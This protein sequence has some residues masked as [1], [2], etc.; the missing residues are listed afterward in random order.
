[1]SKFVEHANL[2]HDVKQLIVGEKYSSILD[3]SLKKLDVEPI[4]CPPNPFIDKR[5]SGH[6]DLSVLH[7][8]GNTVFLSSNLQNNDFANKLEEI[9]T[10][11]VFPQ[12]EMGKKYPND[13][14]YNICVMGND[15]FCSPKVSQNSIVDYLTNNR[16]NRIA[17]KQG[18]CRCSICVVDYRSIITADRGIYLK[19]IE[20]GIDCLLIAPGYIALDGYDYGFIGGCSFKISDRI[21]CFTGT[22]DEHPDKQNI[23]NYLSSKNVEPILLTDL[24]VFDIGSAVPLTEK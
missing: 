15:Y 23:L 14:Q 24:P 17:V 5:L 8:G 9:G 18:Y 21:I 1:M 7:T 3:D 6:A 22:L 16:H 20:N 4:Y 13:S 2:P 11:T 10:K 12:V 19:A